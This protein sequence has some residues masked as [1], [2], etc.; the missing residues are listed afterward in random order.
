MST[1]L[2]RSTHHE[3]ARQHVTGEAIYVDDMPMARDGLLG[4]I[5]TSPHAHATILDCDAT[6]AL[7]VPGVVAVLFGKDIPG[8]NRIGPIVHDEPLL[9]DGTVY[10]TG[11]SVA[12]VLAENEA[13]GRAGV[14]A[15][16]VTY[17]PLDPIL[18]MDAACEAGQFHGDPHIISR[19]DVE[20]ALKQASVRIEG[21]VSCKEQD[22]FYLETQASLA[23]PEE[24]GAFT[25]YSST[26]HPTEIQ[27]MAAEILGIKA[28]QISCVV[29]RLGGGF[30]GKES[31]AT[32]F[33]ALAVLGAWATNRPVK[34]WL[35]RDQDMRQTG[36]RHPFQATYTAG[37]DEN[38]MIVGFAVEIFSDGGW[39][40]DLSLPVLDRAL[41]HLDNS[42]YLP[43]LHFVG[44]ACKT[45]LPSNTAFRGFG[46]PQG[47]LAIEDAINRYA[48]QTGEDPA[49]IRARNYYG[50]KDRNRAPYGQLIPA[51]RLQR[52]WETLS[53]SSD[54]S[55][56][57]EAIDAFNQSSPFIK[58]GIGYQPIKFGISFTKAL[59][60]QAG[61]LVMI[62]ADGSIQINHAGT[63][64]GQGLYTKMIA[65]AAHELGVPVSQI[66]QMATSTEKVPN[67]SPTAAS[68]G[69]DL[70]GQA[71]A[72]A[73]RTLRARLANVAGPLLGT[74]PESV[75]FVDGQVFARENPDAA[76]DFGDVALQ[77]WLQRVSLSATG[78]YA[79]PG[80]AYDHATGSGTPFF[81]FAYGGCVTEVEVNGLTG[82]H[83]IQRIDVLH[84]VGD[85]LVPSIDIGQVEGALVQGLG[86]LTCEELLYRDGALLTH[87]P[88]TYKIPAVGDVPLDLRV[89]LLENAREEM[90]IGGSKAVGEPPFMLAISVVT[91]LRHALSSDAA[92]GQEIKLSIPCTPEAILRARMD[93]I[94]SKPEK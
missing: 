39:T 2:G 74:D 78:F 51:P 55:A 48:E 9:A 12:L 37:F 71:I 42:Y 30:G 79:T 56:R 44:R 86:W 36:N 67:T 63:E 53:E 75:C 17:A 72:D 5:V 29:P 14:E 73:C 80:V 28:H 49:L 94:D 35:N 90:V 16:T 76:I 88:S 24:Q 4:M 52:I 93:L 32:Q 11:Q 34:V 65:V 7:K 26:Q 22:H 87:G 18:S 46:G 61:A 43:A 70:N 85:S 13:A 31:Q 15:V 69:S 64:M 58:R 40:Q 3:S 89:S 23:V 6:N 38:G 10:T 81:Y 84:D 8:N 91:A 57:R 50:Q 47:M 54:Y 19:G 1:P 45:N 27:K 77:A 21:S 66:R 82:E 60:N 59:L 41:F 83:R 25:V 62:Y 20:S 92:P 68:S 33:G